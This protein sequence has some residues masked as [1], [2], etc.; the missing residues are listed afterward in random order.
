MFFPFFNRDNLR[1]ERVEDAPDGDGG[2]GVLTNQ[3]VGGFASLSYA[4]TPEVSDFTLSAMIYCPV[5]DAE[6]GPLAGLAFL[7]DPVRGD[8]YRVVCDFKRADPRIDLAFVG[9]TTLN[10]PVY[11]K[12][13]GPGELPGGVPSKAGW[14]RL[15]VR[16]KDGRAAVYW[17][18][19]ELPGGPFPADKIGRGFA[20]AYA[21]FVGG[22]GDAAAIVDDFS[23]A[24]DMAPAGPPAPPA[25]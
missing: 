19:S 2:V 24:S 15:G 12:L 16:V 6:K 11:L 23:L 14:H 5:S 21:N 9:R 18:G 8:F 20:G 10:Y 4:V 1:G 3:N 7:I 25:N 13:W 22:L 17:N